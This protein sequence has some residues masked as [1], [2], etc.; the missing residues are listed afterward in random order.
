MEALIVVVLVVNAGLLTVLLLQRKSKTDDT[1]ALLLKQDLTT[2]TTGMTE[3]KDG[4]QKQLDEKLSQSN[5][6]MIAQFSESA[7]IIKDVTQKLTELDKTNR[8]V[9]DIAGELKVLQNVLQNPKQRGVLG[10]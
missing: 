4:L 2:L 5:K 9:S 7:K 8:Q 10:E 3:L 1:S 6:Q